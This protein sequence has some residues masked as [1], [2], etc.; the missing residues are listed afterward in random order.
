MNKFFELNLATKFFNDTAHWITFTWAYTWKY[1]NARIENHKLALHILFVSNS[2]N[3]KLRVHHLQTFQKAR[4]QC[5]F[6]VLPAFCIRILNELYCR[7]YYTYIV[8]IIYLFWHLTH[9]IL[10][11][12]PKW[13]VPSKNIHL[14]K[15]CQV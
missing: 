4:L 8:F 12:F 14:L 15:Y 6:Y 3:T 10:R 7:S 11:L 9:V 13:V 1:K 5:I 2:A